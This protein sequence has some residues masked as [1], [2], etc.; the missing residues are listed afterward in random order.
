MP[1]SLVAQQHLKMN[2]MTMTVERM[3]LWQNFMIDIF[4]VFELVKS[5]E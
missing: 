3:D 5:D 1:R 4:L 2:E